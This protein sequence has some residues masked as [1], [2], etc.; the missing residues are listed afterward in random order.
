MEACVVARMKGGVS[1]SVGC[2]SLGMVMMWW[3]DQRVER[4]V[5]GGQQLVGRGMIA[6]QFREHL[7]RCFGRIDLPG[8][9]RELCLVFV[10][11]VHRDL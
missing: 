9:T 4:I 6:G 7:L 10:Q 1:S 2:T 3:V 11:V 5:E 8:D